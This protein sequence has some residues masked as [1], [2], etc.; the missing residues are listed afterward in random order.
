MYDY[1][2]G[3]KDNFKADREA[4]DRM[5]QL[6]PAIRDAA[7]ANRAFLQR[8]VRHLAAEGIDQFLDIGTGIPTA[9][10]THQV[11]QT[12][13]PEA[14]VVY[15]DNDPIVLAHARALMAKPSKGRTTVVQAD[16]REGAAILD[17]RPEITAA[18]DL[19]RPVALMLL[20]VLHFVSD[21]EDPWSTVAG[22]T[23]RLA[24]GSCL[25]ISHGTDDF[26]SKDDS[27]RASGTYR[28]ATAQL[29][30]RSRADIARFFG[31]LELIDPG[32]ELVPRWRNE[33]TVTEEQARTSGFYGAV[34][35]K[36]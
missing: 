28:K 11:A 22:L 1:Y 20:A 2:L 31:E 15:L 5:L 27:A 30:L 6:A 32:L 13:N 23:E 8:T 12:V 21:A 19:D 33:E 36:K 25:V 14:R 34:G 29:H 26:I 4:A 35:F 7:R 16:L 10:N 18:L 3:G 24:P 9:G 17:E